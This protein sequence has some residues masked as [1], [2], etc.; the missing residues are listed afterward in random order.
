MYVSIGGTTLY[1]QP[2]WW[3]G[4]GAHISQCG[5]AYISQDDGEHPVQEAV[6]DLV[7]G[8]DVREAG[9]L[10][11]EFLV[12][13]PLQGV[14]DSLLRGGQCRHKFGYDHQLQCKVTAHQPGQNSE[15]KLQ[16]TKALCT[17]L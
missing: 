11:Q 1:M 10:L 6:V 17:L 14:G 12:A 7:A 4:E 5:G 15:R 9:E 2:P 8:Y 3:G 13:S 16:E